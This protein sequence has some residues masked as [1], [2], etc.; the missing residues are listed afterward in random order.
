MTDWRKEDRIEKEKNL[1]PERTQ[2]MIITCKG[3]FTNFLVKDADHS[4][5][6]IDLHESTVINCAQAFLDSL[7]RVIK[8]NSGKPKEL[9]KGLQNSKEELL[10]R[11]SFQKGQEHTCGQG[12][13]K[14]SYCYLDRNPDDVEHGEEEQAAATA[15]PGRGS[16]NC[17][18][19]ARKPAIATKA[20]K[21][22]F[23]LRISA[24]VSDHSQPL[25]VL[26]DPE[27]IKVHNLKNKDKNNVEENKTDKPLDVFIQDSEASLELISTD[28]L[29]VQI[30]ALDTTID[31]QM[32]VI[33]TLAMNDKLEMGVDDTDL[34]DPEVNH[35]LRDITTRKFKM[36]KEAKRFWRETQPSSA[37]LITVPHVI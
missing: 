32:E 25:T 3:N 21:T 20:L 14:H 11:V 27:V 29:T 35:K 12:V 37:E 31:V 1:T 6:E 34:A 28:V 24:V 16:E 33:D 10:F 19:G 4:V 17:Q 5:D 26:T 36:E 15:V 23:D 8:I 22:G 2:R 13:K 9:A 30:K 18:T 7:D